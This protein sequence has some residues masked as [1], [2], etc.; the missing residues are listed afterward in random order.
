MQQITNKKRFIDLHLHLDGA[1]TASIARSLARLQGM[2]LPPEDEELKRR[3]TVPEGCTSL[4]EFLN[5]F[6]LPCALLQRPEALTLA[7]QLVC[8]ELEAQGVIYEELRFA[9]QKHTDLGMTQEE[10]IVAA[11]KGLKNTDLKANLILCCMRG[12]DNLAENLETV[13][14]AAKYLVEDGGV[15]AIDLAGA[16][17]LYPTKDFGAIFKR[18]REL[19]IPFT[20]HAGEAAGEESVKEAIEFGA[21][22]IG[23][24]VRIANC[25]EIIRLLKE[26]GIVLEMCPTSNSQTC[27]VTDME[28]Y[29]LT[30]LLNQGVKVTVNTDDPAIEGTTIAAEFE[31]LEKEHHLTRELRKE[32]LLNAIDGAF[33][34]EEVKE[35]LRSEIE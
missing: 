21:R 18:A 1:I 20:I 32:L 17:A 12:E 9:P 3:L 16:E 22:R 6:E 29:P 33:T 30:D 15:V 26:K 25:P 28:H 14:L 27:A 7:V 35:K 11:L 4:N 24:G 8:E 13:E 23:H 19:G 31:Y 34:S 2:D 5:C 10:A